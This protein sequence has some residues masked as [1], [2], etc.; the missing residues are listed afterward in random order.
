MEVN[1]I[2]FKGT[3]INK[4]ITPTKIG[5]A[6]KKAET[7]L[8]KLNPR[9]TED[10]AT[11][12]ETE[13]LWKGTNMSGAISEQAE[14]CKDPVF[15]LTTQKEDFYKVNAQNILGMFTTNPLRKETN[16]SEIYRIGATPQ[17][18]NA[19]TK[20]IFSSMLKSFVEFIDK[21]QKNISEVKL[22]ADPDQI[23]TVAK[24]KLPKVTD[25]YNDFLLTKE[26]FKNFINE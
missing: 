22:T 12:R 2:S 19:Q 24:T 7:T 10:M 5:A 1:N 9:N 17:S 3:I 8:V 25:T 16:S 4:N 13:D 26:N 6:W 15:V 23:E 20:H 18:G 21:K 14:I 11:I